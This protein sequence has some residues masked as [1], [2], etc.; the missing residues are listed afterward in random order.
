MFYYTPT[1]E[2]AMKKLSASCIKSVELSRMQ[3]KSVMLMLETVLTL[4]SFPTTVT[5]HSIVLNLK[6]KKSVESA[7][8]AFVKGANLR[9]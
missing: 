5:L 9:N 7:G 6:G 3:A 1:T 4:L 8:V 2:F